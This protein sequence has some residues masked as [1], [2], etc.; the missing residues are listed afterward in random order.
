MKTASIVT[1]HFPCN[2]GAVLQTYG[3]YHY[4]QETGL[5]VIVVNYIPDY[6]KEKISIWYIGNP[7]YKKNPVLR[8]LYYTL[9][10]PLR[11]RQKKAFAKFRA[12]ELKETTPI[13]QTELMNG[14]HINSDFSFCGSDQIWNENNGT[15]SDPIYFLQFVNRD[16]KKFSYA[17]SGTITYPF[18]Q[19]IQS[20]VFPWLRNLDKI[21]V[22]EDVMQQNLQMGLKRNVIQVCDP[23]FLIDKDEWITLSQKVTFRF[24]KKPYIVVY[25]IGNDPTPYK[26]ARELGDRFH[27]P[28]YAISWNKVPFVNKIFKCN[29]YEFLSILSEAKFIITNSFHGTAFSIIF[30]REFWVLNTSIANHRLLSILHKTGLESRLIDKDDTICIEQAIDWG[31]VNLKMRKFIKDSKQYIYNCINL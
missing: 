27:I 12:N 19:N 22:R 28:V 26:R 15:I 18:S 25:A 7:K 13:T 31:N 23:V 21:S 20:K 8:L 6:F 9:M 2:F 16:S 14:N 1:M 4:L 10:V 11:I 29:P 3:L 5:D 24:I 17:A 30:N